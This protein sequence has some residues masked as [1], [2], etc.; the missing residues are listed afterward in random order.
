VLVVDS[1]RGLLPADEELIALLCRRDATTGGPARAA[2]QGRPDQ[3]R[4][5]RSVLAAARQRAQT[6]P[7]QVTAAVHGRG[8]RASRSCSIRSAACCPDDPPA[9]AR[10]AFAHRRPAIIEPNPGSG[11]VKTCPDSRRLPSCRMAGCAR[12][13]FSRRLMRENRLTVDDLIYPCSCWTGTIGAKP[14]ASMRAWSACRS[15]LLLPVAEQCAQ[16]GIPVLALSRSSDPASN[17]TTGARRSPGRAGAAGG[18]G[19]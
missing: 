9:H 19:P 14:V 18:G 13:D 4:R 7:L 15:T 8:A 1:R 16:L 2:E 6:L 12:D 17:R 3:D 5:A 11:N 10:A